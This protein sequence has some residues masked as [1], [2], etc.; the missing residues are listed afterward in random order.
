MKTLAKPTLC[1][2]PNLEEEHI[3]ALQ[4]PLSSYRQCEG[5]IYESRHR[6][7]IITTNLEA[8]PLPK[9]PKKEGPILRQPL[10]D[11]THVKAKIVLA[12]LTKLHFETSVFES[13]SL[14]LSL[15]P[16]LSPHLLLNSSS[17]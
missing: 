3:F 12:W 17:Y 14:S 6:S 8:F 4:T 10:Q 9:N 5:E 15:C 13:L 2:P 1:M 7:I 16:R 11:Y